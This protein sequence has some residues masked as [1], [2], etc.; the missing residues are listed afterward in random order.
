MLRGASFLDEANSIL[1][2]G[3]VA[4][5]IP[6]VIVCLLVFTEPGQQVWTTAREWGT[7][8]VT[9][10]FTESDEANERERK[11]RERLA[12]V[13]PMC[14]A[15]H[16]VAGSEVSEGQAI[17]LVAGNRQV[18]CDLVST[19]PHQAGTLTDWSVHI[20]IGQG[21]AISGKVDGETGEVS[22]R[23]RDCMRTASIHRLG[24]HPARRSSGT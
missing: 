21:C 11:L 10:W 18:D 4:R 9:E 6:L 14:D 7:E 22:E 16:R 23:S 15:G 2:V 8:R 1:W 24:A 12:G 13:E 20:G 5:F 19:E 3:I 17:A